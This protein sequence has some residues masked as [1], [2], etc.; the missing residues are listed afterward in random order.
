MDRIYLFRLC[1]AAVIGI[2]CGLFRLTGI[3]GGLVGISGL[4]G[5]SL[6]LWSRGLRDRAF[7][8]IIEYLGLWLTIWTLVYVEYASL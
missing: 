3:V 1:L 2:L 5:Y 4:V 8:G 7:E 6:F